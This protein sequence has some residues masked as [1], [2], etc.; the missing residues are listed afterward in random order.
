MQFGN[1]HRHLQDDA[2]DADRADAI[3]RTLEAVE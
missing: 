3:A 1:L 2:F